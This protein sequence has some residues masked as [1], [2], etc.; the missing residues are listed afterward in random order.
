MLSVTGL[1]LFTAAGLAA[2]VWWR[3]LKGKEIARGAAA[4][5]CRASSSVSTWVPAGTAGR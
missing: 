4:S 5:A 2:A 3:L 1:L